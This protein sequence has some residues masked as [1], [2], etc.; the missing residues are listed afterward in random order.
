MTKGIEPVIVELHCA[1]QD[2]RSR[3]KTPC[4]SRSN[5]NVVGQGRD[6]RDARFRAEGR[7]KLAGWALK[8][9]RT[10][11]RFRGFV[12]PACLT[13]MEADKEAAKRQ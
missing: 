4:A 7:A 8:E 11:G 9:V 13:F 12:C 6:F 3:G 5:A 10:N 1:Q 2:E